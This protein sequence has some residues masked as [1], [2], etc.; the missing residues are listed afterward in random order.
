VT[1]VDEFR[2]IIDQERVDLLNRQME[3]LR[4]SLQSRIYERVTAKREPV[5]AEYSWVFFTKACEAADAAMSRML[6]GVEKCGRCS[7]KAT[8]DG[9]C[10]YCFGSSG[11]KDPAARDAVIRECSDA[12]PTN[13]AARLRI[14]RADQQDRPRVT[15]T[16]REL[17]KGHPSTWPSQDGEE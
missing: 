9:F 4:D 8:R 6:L 7:A 16:T 1:N 12:I 3:R 2:I 11:Y 15:A 10:V 13:A 17:A 5:Q 14:E